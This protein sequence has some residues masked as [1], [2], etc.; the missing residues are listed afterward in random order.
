MV[1]A[2][3]RPWPTQVVESNGD[4]RDEMF[5]EE[6]IGGPLYENQKHMPRL[7][8]PS[9]SDTLRRFLPTALPLARTEQEKEALKEACRRFPEQAEELQERILRRRNEEFGDSSW[10]QRWWNQVRRSH[11]I[12]QFIL[13]L[14][15]PFGTGHWKSGRNSLIFHFRCYSDYRLVTYKFEIP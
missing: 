2:S 11:S 10:L 1:G 13:S 15:W 7:P 14:L 4:Y 5:L 8:I 9:I 12:L 3:M 6:H